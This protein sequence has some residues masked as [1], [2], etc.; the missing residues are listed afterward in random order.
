MHVLNTLRYIGDRFQI[1]LVAGSV[2]TDESGD[3]HILYANAP[4]ADLFGYGSGSEM[5][6]QDVRSLMPSEISQQHRNH[7][8]LYMS[9]SR[10][11]GTVAMR[12]GWNCRAATTC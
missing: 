7:V 1:A 9:Q 12:L 3:I 6:G 8:D 4:A 2:P 10:Q 11:H 5:E